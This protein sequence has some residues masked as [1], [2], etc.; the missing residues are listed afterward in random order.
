MTSL[1]QCSVWG[2]LAAGCALFVA[3][4]G[5]LA[6]GAAVPAQESSDYNVLL[7]SIDT[8]RADHLGCYGYSRETS[9]NL[10]RL[11]REGVLFEEASA[12]ASWTT[13][14]HMSMLTGLYP[15]T[16]GVMGW[17]TSLG[18]AVPTLAELLGES[19]YATAAIVLAVLHP[20]CGFGRGFQTYDHSTRPLPKGTTADAISSLAID[21][22]RANAKGKKF[23]LFLH[24]WDCHDDYTPPAPFRT[25]FDPDYAGEESGT[26]LRERRLELANKIS[27]EDLA[28][29]IALYDAGIAYTDSVI[30]KVLAELDELQVLDKTLVVVTGDHGE[31]FLEHDRF[32]HGET[33]YEEV[34]HVPLIMRLA[35]VL[36]Q[37]L[38]IP[39]NVSHVDMMP[40]ILGLL[41]IPIPAAIQGSDLS[42][43]CRGQG[44][45]PQDRLVFCELKEG[46][47][48]MRAVRW[49]PFKVIQ[50]KGKP[51]MPLLVVDGWTERPALEAGLDEEMCREAEAHLVE[52]LRAGPTGLSSDPAC[53]AKPGE[54]DKDLVDLLR[55]LGYLE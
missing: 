4:V 30:G 3:V 37:G 55:S 36:P 23:F 50:E 13:P 40:T 38:R 26:M 17:G 53:R 46:R 10:D 20:K 49:G 43:A 52:A 15:S 32:I 41:R 33:L 44:E 11:A 29:L 51:P 27:R 39:G 1:H 34:L 35:G 25:M 16:H 2:R 9:P 48:D 5:G 54:L 6:A 19:G 47:F 28:H 12:A 31:G 7:I 42:A 18:E 21:W 14:S 45:V 8:L 22:L 24:Y